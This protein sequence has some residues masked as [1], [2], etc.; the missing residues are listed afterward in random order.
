MPLG[1]L[2]SPQLLPALVLLLPDTRPQRCALPGTSPQAARPACSP[3]ESPDDFESSSQYGLDLLFRAPAEEKADSAASEGRREPSEAD[4]SIEFTAPAAESHPEPSRLDDWFLGNGCDSKPRSVHEELTKSWKA[5]LSARSR[6]TNSPPLTTLDGG[7]A[8]RYTE[9]PQVERARRFTRP[10][11]HAMAILQV[12]QPKVLKDLH[13]GAPDP[14]LLQELR[15][16]TDYALRA[17]KVTAQALG[18]AMSTMMVQERHLWLNLAEMR[19]VEKVRFLDAP[20]SQAGRFTSRS[21]P[22]TGTSGVTP[23]RPLTMVSGPFDFASRPPKFHGVLSI[24][25]RGENTVVLCAEIAVLLAKGCDRDCPLDRNEERVLQHLPHCTQ[26][27]R[28]QDWFV[29]ID[30]K[31][32]YFHVLILPRHRPFLRFAFEGRAYQYKVLPFG[33]SLSPR[34]FMKVAEAALAPLREVGIHI[35]NYLDDRL[36]L[37]H[38]WDLVCT[39]RDVVFNHLAQLGQLGKEQTLPSTEYLFSRCVTGLSQYVWM[40]LPRARTVSAEVCGN[41]QMQVYGPSETNSEA[42]GAHDILSRGHAVGSDAHETATT[43]ALFPSPEMGMAPRHVSCEHHTIV[44]QNT[45]PLDRHFVPAVRGTLGISVQ[46]HHC[47]YRWLQDRLGCYNP[48]TEITENAYAHFPEGARAASVTFVKVRG[49]R[50]RPQGEPCTDEPDLEERV[51]EGSRH[52]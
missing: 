34:V 32:A 44:S 33:L 41:T 11:V 38:S 13:E 48:V 14:E 6:Y 7:P 8:R 47:H 18:K 15:S 27:G 37:A 20:I 22:T 9:V 50:D 23:L 45:Q 2:R 51:L 3:M 31:D 5:P 43:L 19:D 36:I 29:E 52:D 1:T 10:L 4:A 21:A 25:V 49:D 17:T 46:T 42:P 16:V 28:A 39:H 40:S 35:L 12:Y 26:E 30:L 24:S